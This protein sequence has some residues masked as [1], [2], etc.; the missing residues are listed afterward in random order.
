[1]TDRVERLA[2]VADLLRDRALSDLRLAAK[3]RDSSLAA[4]A[5]L[6]P[7]KIAA[8][9]DTADHVN[10]LRHQTWAARQ[11]TELNLA[12]AGQ[13]AVWIEARAAA[14]QAVGRSDALARKR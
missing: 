14:A 10:A 1:M 12:L 4:L 3:A 8:D 2:M 6:A 9:A 13:T 5:A 11:R 7:T